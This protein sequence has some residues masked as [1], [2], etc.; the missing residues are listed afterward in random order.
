MNQRFV[1][2]FRDV[3]IHIIAV[4][5]TLNSSSHNDFTVK[6]YRKWSFWK[7]NNRF[8]AMQYSFITTSPLYLYKAEHGPTDFLNCDNNRTQDEKLKMMII[9]DRLSCT[10]SYDWLYK[11][12]SLVISVHGNFHPRRGETSLWT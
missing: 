5:R 8:L 11:S 2:C 7:L 12:L 9:R 3:A 4:S 1:T 10:F 6:K